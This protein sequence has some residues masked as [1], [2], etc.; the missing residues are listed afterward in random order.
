MMGNGIRIQCL[1]LIFRR[2]QHSIAYMY[3]LLL[4]SIPNFLID[5]VKLKYAVN[6]GILSRELTCMIHGA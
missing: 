4:L 2:L 3:T 6:S 1:T 5:F